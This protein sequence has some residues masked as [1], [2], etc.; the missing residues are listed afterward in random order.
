MPARSL[1]SFHSFRHTAASEAIKDGES[2]EEVSWQLGH[3][4]SNVTRSVYVQEIR[5]VERTA[6]RREKYEA[7][8]GGILETAALSDPHQGD[9]DEAGEC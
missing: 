1:P 7:R 5:D 2:A 9:S 3:R 6:A 4:N 8:I